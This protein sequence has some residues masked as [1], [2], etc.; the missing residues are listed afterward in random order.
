MRVIDYV[1]CVVVAVLSA[2]LF[3]LWVG[4]HPDVTKGWARPLCAMVVAVTAFAVAYLALYDFERAHKQ[5]LRKVQRATPC[6]IPNCPDCRD[7][8][9]WWREP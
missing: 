4:P 3:A 2:L 1:M 8:N 7:D 6:T 5:R 9:D